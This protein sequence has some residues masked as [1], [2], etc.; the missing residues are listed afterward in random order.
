MDVADVYP[1]ADGGAYVISAEGK[2]WYAKGDRATRVTN[3]S[4]AQTGPR[5]PNSQA[6]AFTLLSNEHR[7]ARKLRD[8]LDMAESEVKELKGER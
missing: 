6:A 8:A 2:L 3:G 7:R 5:Q 1:T 4:V